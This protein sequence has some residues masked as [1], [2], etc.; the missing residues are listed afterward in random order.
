MK[1]FFVFVTGGHV[2]ERAAT[3]IATLLNDKNPQARYLGSISIVAPENYSSLVPERPY[4]DPIDP[5]SCRALATSVHPLHLKP[6]TLLARV[7]NIRIQQIISIRS[8]N[9]SSRRITLFQARV[10]K[11]RNWITKMLETLC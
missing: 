9:K 4:S 7:K 1:F 11:Q 8:S 2:V 5:N 3:I 10:K 6:M